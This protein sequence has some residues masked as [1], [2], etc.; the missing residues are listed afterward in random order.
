L[1]AGD[2]DAEFVSG[3]GLFFAL[4]VF[5]TADVAGGGQVGEPLAEALRDLPLK[6]RRLRLW[7]LIVLARTFALT[8]RGEDRTPGDRL[9]A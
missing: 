1:A 9:V 6:T 5:L 3:P 8:L 7:P 2:V 4:A